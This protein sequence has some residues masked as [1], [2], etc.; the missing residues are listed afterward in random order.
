MVGIFFNLIPSSALASHR[1]ESRLTASNLAQNEL[2]KMR[3][4]PYADLVK[5]HGENK[6]VQI[7][8]TRYQVSTVV[9]T[10]PGLN[11]DHVKLA[12]VT[13]NWRDKLKDQELSYE[14]RMFQQNR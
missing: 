7:G 9:K 2:E 10:I 1:A 5:R 6:E 12:R 14:L 3:A 11:P 13:V 4:D 8:S